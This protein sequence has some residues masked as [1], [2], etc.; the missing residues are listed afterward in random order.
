[1][2]ARVARRV[3]PNV[4]HAHWILPNAALARPYA[5]KTGT[6]LVVSIHGSDIFLAER[7]GWLGRASRRTLGMA[8]AVTACSHDLANR[9]MALGAPPD[10]MHVLPYGV[11]VDGFRP[12][13]AAMKST[14]RVALG[15]RH[16]LMVL[17]VG[18]LVGKKGFDVLLDAVARLPRAGRP[19]LVLAGD[20]DLREA[21]MRQATSL[22][23]ETRFMGSVDR[24]V[25]TRL[26]HAAD[27]LIVP[28]V[29]DTSGNVDGLPNV[30][31]EGLA[32]GV[33][34]ITSRIGGLPDILT[35]GVTARLV[36]PGDPTSLAGALSELLGDSSL[37]TRLAQAGRQLAEHELPWPVICRRLLTILEGAAR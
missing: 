14:A 22:D 26:Y 18:R 35:N 15:I 31:L 1:M 9:A 33:P 4:I 11:D 7:H 36:T 3:Q 19:L 29:T 6:P 34:L 24:D 12:A 32:A 13:D 30:A 21:L 10:R 27:V 23:L 16:Q 17:A 5:A 37:R 8:A 28:S 25:L 20:G 2:L